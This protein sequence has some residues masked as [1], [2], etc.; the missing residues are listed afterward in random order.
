MMVAVCAV[1]PP[2]PAYVSFRAQEEA[3]ASPAPSESGDALVVSEPGS[4]SRLPTLE[5]G[6]SCPECEDASGEV[7]KVTMLASLVSKFNFQKQIIVLTP[8]QLLNISQLARISQLSGFEIRPS[9]MK[10]RM[11]RI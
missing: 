6:G 5:G 8:S 1:L 2:P 4:Q 10:T 11:L 3:V 9:G 7:V